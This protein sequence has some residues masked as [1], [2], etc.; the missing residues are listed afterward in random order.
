MLAAR[1]PT[2]VLG[3]APDK[4][5]IQWAPVVLLPGKDKGPLRME[6]RSL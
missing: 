5:F 4:G 6:T 2:E 1:E 3:I